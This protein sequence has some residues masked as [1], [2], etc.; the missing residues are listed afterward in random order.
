MGK[1]DLYSHLIGGG[2]KGNYVGY[3]ASEE[4]LSFCKNKYP[5]VS[6][7]N[8]YLPGGLPKDPCDYAFISGTLYDKTDDEK[9]VEKVLTEVFSICK[10]GMAFNLLS[11]HVDYSVDGSLYV[12]P[13]QIFSFCMESLSRF[14]VLRNDYARFEFTVYV[15]KKAT[16]KYY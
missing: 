13:V 1:R 2:W 5:K 8:C 12:D 16:C 9:F 6:F 11:T 4:M 3:D 7:I 15:Y 10:C 14:I